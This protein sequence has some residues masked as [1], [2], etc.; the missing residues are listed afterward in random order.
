MTPLLLKWPAWCDWTL[1]QS[2]TYLKLLRSEVTVLQAS[3]GNCWNVPVFITLSCDLTWSVPGDMAHHWCWLS[4]AEPHPVLGP[5]RPPHRAVLLQQYVP[6]SPSDSSV[7]GESAA[8]LSSSKSCSWRIN[9][10]TPL[11]LTLTENIWVYYFFSSLLGRH[12]VLHPSDC[13]GSPLWQ[14]E[15]QSWAPVICCLTNVCS[16]LV[17]YVETTTHLLF[18]CPDGL[19]EG[20]HPVGCT[21][22]PASGPPVHL[23]HEDQHIYGWRGTPKRSWVNARHWTVIPLL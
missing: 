11:T 1:G 15:Q 8:L 20:V 4:W 9:L 2:V 17:L 14:G 5:S 3:A 6:S 23:E 13:A 12:L 22:V 18:S 7:W 21:E 16:H 10:W 19:R